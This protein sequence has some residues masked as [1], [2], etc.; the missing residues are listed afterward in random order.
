MTKKVLIVDDDK[1]SARLLEV[2]VSALGYEVKKLFD[3]SAAEATI[4]EY[5]PY[6]IL[7]DLMMPKVHGYM[8]LQQLRVNPKLAQIKVIIVSAKSYQADKNKALELGANGYITKP[9]RRAELEAE[10]K[11]LLTGE[12]A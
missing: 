10:V 1:D 6:L 9:F 8:I 4:M 5:Q 11:R 2:I 7:L 12:A 3:G